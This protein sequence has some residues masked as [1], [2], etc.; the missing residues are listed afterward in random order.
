M[1]ELKEVISCHLNK[2]KNE[3]DFLISISDIAKMA[4]I[5]KSN[6]YN[7]FNGTA[8]VDSMMKVIKV[9]DKELYDKF[10]VLIKNERS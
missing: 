10:L 1:N 3:S 6:A 7:I 9:L 2:I 5:K 4:G 8:S